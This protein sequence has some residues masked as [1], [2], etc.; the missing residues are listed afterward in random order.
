MAVPGRMNSA[1]KR[2]DYVAG[3]R[4]TGAVS[5]VLIAAL[6]VGLIGIAAAQDRGRGSRPTAIRH[7]ESAEHMVMQSADRLGT[8]SHAPRTSVSF[9]SLGR[10]FDLEVEPSDLITPA[11]RTVWI[12]DDRENEDAPTDFLYQGHVQGV[13]HSWVR[14][15]IRNGLLDGMIWTPTETYF[16]QPE[17]RLLGKPGTDRTMVYRMSDVDPAV[18]H[19]AC[20]TSEPPGPSAAPLVAHA[21]AEVIAAPLLSEAVAGAASPLQETTV[22]LVADYDYFVNHGA[23]AAA[24]M[25]SIINQVD[26]VY[27]AQLGVDLHV[28]QTVVYT[29]MPDPFDA[30][31]DPT[32]LLSEFSTYKGSS[33]SPVY[34]ADIAYLFTGRALDGGVLGISWIGTLCDSTYSTALSQ[35]F[36]ADNTSL[37]L[38]AAH[39]I[40]HVFGA[41]HDN[42]AGSPC[43]STPFGFIMNPYISS[44]L[45]LQF[46]GCS[47]SLMDPDIAG[48]SCLSAS[49]LSSA[50]PTPSPTATASPMEPPPPTAT[51]TPTAAPTATL[52][53]TPTSPLTRSTLT[54]TPTRTRTRTPTPTRTHTRTPTPTPVRRGLPVPTPTPWWWYLLGR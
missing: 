5:W 18:L 9:R 49:I 51:R 47:L 32:T 36:T 30:T 28:T 35:D 6:T 10:Q 37:L 23:N 12:R 38:L 46:S 41:Y 54:P 44:A 16:V 48:A 7:F 53:K 14:I 21:G 2:V 15:S 45:S 27:Q 13:P 50:T 39:E 40:G 42:Q 19:G 33:G 1:L 24:D 43:A 22:A 3:L 11:H 29:T 34:G 31:T 52:T 20:G 26:G 8:A 17:A 4:L 25:L